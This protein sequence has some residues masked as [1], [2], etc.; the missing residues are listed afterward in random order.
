MNDFINKQ[1]HTNYKEEIS[2]GKGVDF[3]DMK[4]GTL[5]ALYKRFLK[6]HPDFKNK[7]EDLDHFAHFIVENPDKFS[8]I[9]NKKAQF[10]VNVLSPKK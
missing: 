4:W 3:E 9:A 6:Q 2:K 7:I 1:E 10:Y 5:T 8:K